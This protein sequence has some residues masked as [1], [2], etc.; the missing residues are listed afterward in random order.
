MEQLDSLWQGGRPAEGTLLQL[1]SCV[2][3][4]GSS[5]K[6]C[7]LMACVLCAVNSA[8]MSRFSVTPQAGQAHRDGSS[9]HGGQVDIKA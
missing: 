8:C 5:K 2:W 7:L 4:E 9:A 6:A 1:Q 3:D